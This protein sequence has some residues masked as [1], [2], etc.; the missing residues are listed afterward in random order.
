MNFKQEY[1]GKILHG[2]CFNGSSLD[3]QKEAPF[4]VKLD[5]LKS[6]KTNFYFT[7]ISLI[8]HLTYVF[9]K[10]LCYIGSLQG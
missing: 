1:N 9:F 7:K 6:I 8:F 3:L 5:T 2:R 10:L 4:V